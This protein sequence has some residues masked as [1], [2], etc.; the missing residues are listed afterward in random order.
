MNSAFDAKIKIKNRKLFN[1][2]DISRFTNKADSD[3]EIKEN[4]NKSKIISRAR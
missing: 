1:K 4:R 2:S 3:G